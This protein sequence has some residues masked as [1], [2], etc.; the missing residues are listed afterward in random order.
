M[1]PWGANGR[2]AALSAS[3]SRNDP[4]LGLHH[5]ALAHVQGILNLTVFIH[6]AKRTFRW[7]HDDSVFV[8]FSKFAFQIAFDFTAINGLFIEL[9]QGCAIRATSVSRA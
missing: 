4:L 2:F 8:V 5:F 6:G 7:Q 1:Q 3:D 9:A